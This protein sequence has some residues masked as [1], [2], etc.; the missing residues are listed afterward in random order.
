[1]K[2]YQA[3]MTSSSGKKPPAPKPKAKPGKAVV[4]FFVDE[5]A[6]RILEVALE[7]ETHDQEESLNPYQQ[8]DELDEAQLD[9]VQ[10]KVHHLAGEL[11]A[12][13]QVKE[14]FDQFVEK[15]DRYIEHRR[16]RS[17]NNVNQM[18]RTIRKKL[19]ELG[20]KQ[21]SSTE[22]G[23]LLFIMGRK[24]RSIEELIDEEFG[25]LVA[26]FER[27]RERGSIFAR[28]EWVTGKDF[29]RF[30]IRDVLRRKS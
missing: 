20:V 3:I 1:M 28:P 8:F 4:G 17:R 11:F 16:V 10:S 13:Q 6:K 25:D 24:T 15:A 29:V 18:R 2:L 30:L 7:G 27:K 19:K 14:D 12:S 21:V 23:S 5:D 22:K 26:A 9:A